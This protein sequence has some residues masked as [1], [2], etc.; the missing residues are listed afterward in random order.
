MAMGKAEKRKRFRPEEVAS[1]CDQIAMLLNSGIPLY[2]GAYILAQEVEDKRTQQVLMRVEELV[3]ENMP[4]Y[5]ALEDTGAF[6]EYMVHMVRVGETTG[7]LEDVLRSLSDYYGRDADVKAAIR[8]AVTFPAVLFAMMAVIMLV[9]VFK[10]I[11][12]F[13]AMFLELNA[14]VAGS[15]GRMMNGGILAGKILAGIT[16]AVFIIF[17]LMFLWYHTA[18]G[19]RAIKRLGRSFGPVGRLARRMAVGQFVSSIGLMMVSGMDQGEALALTEDGCLDLVVKD[20]IAKCRALVKEGKGFD[21]AL[22]ESRLIV[23]RDNRMIGV[24]MRTGATD[25]ILTKLGR[26]YD[27]KITASLMAMS[28]KIETAMVVLLAVMV[29]TVL[30]SIMLPLVGMLSAIG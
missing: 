26:Q 1:F 15:T 23:G 13:E 21:E 3:R 5:G 10:I 29:G 12:M 22:R 17:I 2:E 19:E 6:P 16:C 18:A 4:L 9:M 27:E 7:K 8:S 25:E 24:A 14:E 11:P 30:I 28:G 20:R